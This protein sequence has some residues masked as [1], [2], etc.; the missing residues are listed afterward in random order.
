M[1]C[2]NY[3]YQELPVAVDKAKRCFRMKYSENVNRTKSYSEGFTKSKNNKS[4]SQ[5]KVRYV[6]YSFWQ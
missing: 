2:I 4:F 6:L 1:E 3:E 5:G